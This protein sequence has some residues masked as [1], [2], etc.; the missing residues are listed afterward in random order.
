MYESFPFSFQITISRVA[1]TDSTSIQK[2]I[3]SVAAITFFDPVAVQ[4]QSSAVRNVRLLPVESSKLQNALVG[5]GQG[6]LT[7]RSA[8]S[9]C[10][11][12]ECSKSVAISEGVV[13]AGFHGVAKFTDSC[14]DR[15]DFTG[16]CNYILIV[17]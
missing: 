9:N 2:S 4:S 17:G 7:V 15:Q 10:H 12:L 13:D 16:C 1:G 6:P 11:I 14:E 8:D 5:F 3:F